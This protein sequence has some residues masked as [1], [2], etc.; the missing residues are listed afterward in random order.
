MWN[1]GSWQWPAWAIPNENGFYYPC[2]WG[3]TITKFQVFPELHLKGIQRLLT[4]WSLEVNTVGCTV[5]RSQLLENYTPQT[6][7]PRP[8]QG[9]WSRQESTGPGKIQFFW[10]FQDA[11]EA[12]FDC[13]W[14]SL[15]TP[16]EVPFITCRHP[17]NERIIHLMPV[18]H[19]T[20]LFL[21]FSFLS[22]LLVSLLLLVW[23]KVLLWSPD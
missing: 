8:S 18:Y 3:S 1:E 16:M 6:L 4:R 15:N 14:S 22:T 19:P 9:L 5:D 7:Y 10:F 2:S 20:L 11:S 12:H 13:L 21:L 17:L 23:Y